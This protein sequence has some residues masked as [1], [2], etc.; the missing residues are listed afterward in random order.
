MEEPKI[1]R[2]PTI[3]FR[4]INPSD[5]ERLEQIHRDIFPIRLLNYLSFEDFMCNLVFGF[6]FPFSEVLLKHLIC[7]GM[8]LSFFRML[9]TEV[10]LSLGLLLIGA[11]LM[12]IPR[13][14]LVLL[15]PKSCLPKKAK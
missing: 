8:N 15:L 4:P 9:S 11:G 2:R 1:A 10:I 13:N 14:L 6:D 3:C 12:V 5:L 7:S